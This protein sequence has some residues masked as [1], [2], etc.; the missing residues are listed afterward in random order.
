MSHDLRTPLNAIIGFAE[1]INQG[2]FG[3]LD[4]RYREYARDISS[5]AEH[6]RSLV[7]DLLNLSSIEAGKL[8]LTREQVPAI[9]Q[10]SMSIIRQRAETRGVDLVVD[11]DEDLPPLYADRRAV[12][13]IL[14]NL[15]SNAI[16]FT[17]A[18]GRIKL[19]ATHCNRRHILKVS[20]TGEGIP[21]KLLSVVTEPFVRGESDPHKFQEST[22][23]GLAIVKSLV[24]MHGGQLNIES[25]LGKGTTVTVILPG[26]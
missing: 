12:K 18:D 22:G 4:A 10:E 3:S 7:N 5:S 14:L 20:D 19:S 23:L 15:L 11:V 9:L 17:S 8:N 16:R 13:Q 25:T 1:I 24:T 2:Y 6:L 26:K 21:P